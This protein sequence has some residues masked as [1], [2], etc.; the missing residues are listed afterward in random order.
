MFAGLL[1][2]ICFHLSFAPNYPRTN[3]AFMMNKCKT[4]QRFQGMCLVLELAR[5]LRFIAPAATE[6]AEKTDKHSN[7]I[8][9]KTSFKT[10]NII[11]LRKLSFKDEKGFVKLCR[12]CQRLKYMSIWKYDFQTS[13]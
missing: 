6:A 9:S 5:L 7:S 8:L 2:G 12:R 13:L 1:F 3:F 10:S 4:L 11:H